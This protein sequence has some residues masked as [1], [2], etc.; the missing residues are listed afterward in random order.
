MSLR[1]REV[2]CRSLLVASKLP[3]SDYVVNPYVGCSFACAYCYASFMGRFVGEPVEMWGQ[4]LSVKVNAVEV[5]RRDLR[6]LPPHKRSSTLLLSSVT[7]AW[8]GV[9]KKYG[10]ARGVLETLRDDAYPGLVTLLTK[11]PLVLRDVEVIAAL[12]QKEVG[13]TITT[14]DDAMGRF[15]EVHAPGASDRL[16]T[17]AAL[18]KA[19]IPTYAFVGPLLPHYRYRQDQLEALFRQIREAGTRSLF[20]EHLNSSP[21]ILKRLRPLIDGADAEVRNVYESARTDEHRQILS[22][23]VLALAE[24]YGLEIRLGRVLDHPRDKK[25]GADRD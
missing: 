15:L 22:E 11:S 19:G 17:L 12:A 14:T 16:R 13:V 20:V 1:L 10:L 5:F 6:R 8:Q 18:N 7:D 4:Y 9:E 3:A 23:M 24:K 21:Y 2:L 25:S